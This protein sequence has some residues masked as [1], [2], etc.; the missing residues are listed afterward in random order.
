MYQKLFFL[1]VGELNLPLVRPLQRVNDAGHYRYMKTQRLTTRIKTIHKYKH[2][3]CQK[4]KIYVTMFK[5][6]FQTL[7]RIIC[8]CLNMSTTT[9]RKHST[10]IC[11]T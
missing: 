7:P 9:I 2:K 5:H 1:S 3:T 4:G 8:V 11:G 6:N 10:V